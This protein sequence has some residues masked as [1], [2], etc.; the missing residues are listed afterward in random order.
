MS[1]K[2]PEPPKIVYKQIEVDPQEIERRLDLAFGVLFEFVLKTENSL[3]SRE[4]L[5][6]RQLHKP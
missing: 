3:D 6:N 4:E 2:M 1:K 5:L